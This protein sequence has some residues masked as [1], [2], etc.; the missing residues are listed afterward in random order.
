MGTEL[1]ES[2]PSLAGVFLG[3]RK[4][5]GGFWSLGCGRP[6]QRPGETVPGSDTWGSSPVLWQWPLCTLLHL[7]TVRQGQLPALCWAVLGSRT[8]MDRGLMTLDCAAG[9]SSDLKKK[10]CP[11]YVYHSLESSDTWS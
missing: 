2:F 4:P 9:L 11:C 5:F 1:G 7:M 6:H 10:R 8:G 3:H